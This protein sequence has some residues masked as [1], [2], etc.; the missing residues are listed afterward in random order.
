MRCHGYHILF[1]HVL[2]G[3]RHTHFTAELSEV[4]RMNHHPKKRGSKSEYCKMKVIH[5]LINDVSKTENYKFNK[6]YKELL[7]CILTLIMLRWHFVHHWALQNWHLLLRCLQYNK[8]HLWKPLNTLFCNQKS[9]FSR[10]LLEL[11]IKTATFSSI[12][13]ANEQ[14]G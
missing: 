14:E 9:E 2:S 1:S 3:Q 12:T 6:H 8:S 13:D 11:H 10:Y 7:C 4:C 5:M